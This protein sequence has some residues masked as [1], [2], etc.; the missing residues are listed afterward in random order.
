MPWAAGWP[1][2]A[3]AAAAT[4]SP[5]SSSSMTAGSPAAARGRQAGCGQRRAAAGQPKQ[6]AEVGESVGAKAPPWIRSIRLSEALAGGV[7]LGRA[8][9]SSHGLL[10]AL[11]EEVHRAD[12]AVAGRR[13]GV[14][15]ALGGVAPDERR[16]ARGP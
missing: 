15:L 14:D 2:F 6:V 1:P 11:E 7:E 16:P 8:E 5:A 12:G 10:R 3:D 9:A 13:Q 4:I